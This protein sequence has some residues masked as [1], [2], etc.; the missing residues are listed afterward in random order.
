MSTAVIKELLKTQNRLLRRIERLEGKDAPPEV[1]KKASGYVRKIKGTI[2]TRSD[3]H[4]YIENR[5]AKKRAQA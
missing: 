5:F 1:K 4:Q 3:A 2:I